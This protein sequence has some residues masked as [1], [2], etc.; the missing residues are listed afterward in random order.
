MLMEKVFPAD[1]QALS[2]DLSV[3]VLALRNH[4]MLNVSSFKE[5]SGVQVPSKALMA[6]RMGPSLR[7]PLQR[8][9]TYL[10]LLS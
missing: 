9:F 1:D 5:N 6:K 10:P 3:W 4:M 7:R 2:Q 8:T